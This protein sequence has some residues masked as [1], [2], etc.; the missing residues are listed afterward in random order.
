MDPN[1][2]QGVVEPLINEVQPVD[3]QLPEPTPSSNQTTTELND[4]TPVQ[5]DVN[6]DNPRTAERIQQLLDEN[7]R[8]KADH[9]VK[10][11]G[12]SVFDSFQPEIPQSQYQAPVVPN[13]LTQQ[14]VSQLRNDYIQADGTVDINGFNQAIT[15]AIREAQSAKA[16]T[17]R[18]REEIT[19]LEETQQVR[20]AHKE[21]PW[22][23]PQSPSFDPKGYE[24]VRDKMLSNMVF[25]K[26]TS[27]LEAANEVSKIYQPQ[28]PVDVA[29]VKEQGVQEGF[30]QA[31]R[32]QEL[33][34]QGPIEAGNGEPRQNPDR[35]LAD[36]RERTRKGD[37]EATGERLKALG[38]VKG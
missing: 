28:P 38:I 37:I 31:K 22:L 11:Y 33:R 5:G 20:E 24:L 26:R 12:S 32:T 4:N 6:A 10:Q 2:D 9:N 35:D 8:L 13:G 15:Q 29:K 36:L 14:D 30:Q 19:R 16:E 21:H 18:T 23:D 7:K 1:Q 34:N 25:H 3:A 27:L 17:Q